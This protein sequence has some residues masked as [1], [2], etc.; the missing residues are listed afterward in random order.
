MSS[1]FSQ[2]RISRKLLLIS[3]AYLLPLGVLI[4]N[5]DKAI[6]A[7]INFATWEKYG[8]QIQRPL[9]ELLRQIGRRR[10][11]LANQEGVSQTSIADITSQID[12]AFLN[13][14]IS[15]EDVK[16]ALQFTS[17]GLG[18]RNRSALAFENVLARW[19]TIK[20]NSGTSGKEEADKAQVA[21]ISDIRGMI[22][23]AGD[24]SNLILDPDLDSYYLMDVTLLALPQTQD[25]LTEVLVAGLGILEKGSLTAEDKV[26]LAVY[27][28]MLKEADAGRV[29]AD[30][31]TSL[32]EDK[33]F[34]GSSG[35]Y[36]KNYPPALKE[37]LDASGVFIQ[38]L[39]D[40]ANGVGE[41]PSKESFL[42]AGSKV[43]ENSFTLWK[44]A[45]DELDKLLDVRISHY[46]F[47]LVEDLAPAIIALILSTLLVFIIQRSITRSII[48]VASW[49][50][51]STQQI[52]AGSSEI[53]SSSDAL[54]QGA[55]QQA[56]LLE[57][58]AASLEEIGT[59]AH[60][61]SESS[62]DAS[63]STDSVQELS[64]NG[65]EAMKEMARAVSDIKQAANETGE[66]IRTI[67]EI[68]FQ[69]NLLALN[70]A[71]EA[72]RAGEAGKGFAVVADEV[73]A[74]AQRSSTAAKNTGDK[75]QRSRELSDRGVSVAEQVSQ[76]LEKIRGAGEQAAAITRKISTAAREQAGGIQ[77]INTSVADLE[78]VTQANSAASEEFAAT[79]KELSRQAEK[80][81]D[82]VAN[83]NTLAYGKRQ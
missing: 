82:L 45:V 10:V 24:T 20:Q 26:K 23:H 52:S 74:L 69:T 9:E 50:S 18:S 5:V 36:Q 64:K 37:Y 33:N 43:L 47:A 62:L 49:I 1:F 13:L 6:Y 7:N 53:A 78:Q 35:S 54:A 44:V 16:E 41:L 68:S 32:N 57:S 65:V 30:S 63:R 71:V 21:L 12:R 4:Y 76:I 80:L 3:L 79:S 22:T 39:N 59:A 42:N 46:E 17:D 31:A 58:T 25:R 70:A 56:Q 15:Y 61:S 75:L 14:K 29:E 83:L 60:E 27:S 40:M 55:S 38:M 73:R 77:Q 2:L 8:N 48:E 66:I 81:L 11:A 67:D 51:N 28:A 72:A 19:E 34:Y